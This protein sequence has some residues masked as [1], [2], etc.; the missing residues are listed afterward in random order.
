MDDKKEKTGSEVLDKKG[1]AKE[2]QVEN[3]KEEYE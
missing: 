2:H 1:K 3:H